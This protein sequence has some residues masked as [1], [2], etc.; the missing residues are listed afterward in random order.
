MSA[1]TESPLVARDAL[2]KRTIPEMVLS[3][4]SNPLTAPIPSP[5]GL[6]PA[7]RAIRRFS[8]TGNAIVTGGAGHLG[9]AAV[10]GLLEHGATGI[11]VFDL[12]A[13]LV[14]AQAEIRKLQTEFPQARFIALEVDITDENAIDKAIQE[15]K[16]TLGAIDMLLCFAG[17]VANTHSVDVTPAEWK[18][19]LEINTTGS[20]LCA[21]AVA[22]QMIAHGHGGSILFISSIAGHSILYPQPQV[23]YNVSKAGVLHLTRCLAAEWARYGIR[24]NCISPGYMDTIL[25]TGDSLAPARKIWADRNPMGRMGQPD[26]LTG[27]VI[28]LCS[29]LAGRYITGEN[30]TIDGGG[31]VF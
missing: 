15:V 17:V 4:A 31:N 11:A 9:L 14:S 1:P 29:R 30:I 12:P 27:V 5:E 7:E 21:Q 20:W 19:V 3:Q 2:A 24:V 28:L 25:N 23:A 6:T 8:V 18:R 13:T 16:S 22:K 26:E 10:Q